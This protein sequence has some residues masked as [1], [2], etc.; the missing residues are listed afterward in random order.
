MILGDEEVT[1]LDTFIF[2]AITGR[3]QCGLDVEAAQDL[4]ANFATWLNS[5]APHEPPMAWPAWII[6]SYVQP[7]TISLYRRSKSTSDGSAAWFFELFDEFLSARGLAL[8]EV[9]VEVRNRWM[10]W[11]SR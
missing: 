9:T 10:A 4:L 2:G 1:T 6:S 7:E 8:P 5:K 11:H 3:A